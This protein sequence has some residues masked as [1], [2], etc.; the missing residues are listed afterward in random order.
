MLKRALMWVFIAAGTVAAA[1]ANAEPALKD[2]QRDEVVSAFRVETLYEDYAGKVMGGRFRHLPTG[3]VLDVLRIQSVPQGFIWVNSFPPSD[4]GE[5]HTCEHLLLGKGTKGRYVGSLEAMSLGESSAFTMQLQTCYHFHTS[6]GPDTFYDLLEAK[7][8]ALLHPNFS[9]EE[10]RREVCNMGY[11]IDPTDSSIRLEEKGTV[12]N[13]MVSGF[14]RPGSNVWRQLG[15]TLYGQGHPLARSSGGYPPAIRTMTPEDMRSFHRDNYHLGN[16]GMVLAVPDEIPLADLLARASDIFARVQPEAELGSDPATA[17]DR[18]PP[19]VSAPGGTIQLVG[20]PH[21]NPDEPGLLMYA[22]PPQL[23]LDNNEEYLLELFIANIAGG[24]TSDL[25][26]KFI[27]SR[28]REIDLGANAV[29]GWVSTEEGYPVHIGLNNV[30]RDALEKPMI[31]SVRSIIQGEIARVVAFAD[32]S[33]DLQAFNERIR[34]KVI[35]RRRDLRDFLN[36]PPGFGFRGSGANWYEHLKHLQKVKGF[37]KRI[38]LDPELESVEALLATG[39]NFWKEY[40][41]RW[42]LIDVKPYAI[43]GR[44]DPAM[45]AESEAARDKRIADFVQKLKQQYGAATEAEAIA[46]FKADY[47]RKTEEIEAEASRIPMPKFVDNPP[48]TLDAQLHYKVDT[49]ADGIPDVASTFD[50]MPG[51]TIG[52]ALD[53]HAVPESLLV[54]AAALP[55]LLTEVGVIRDGTPI[56]YDEMKEAIR[57][58]ILYLRAYYDVNP[59]TER[60]ELVLK[61]SGSELNESRRALQWLSAALYSPD[62][63]PENLP[64]IRDAVAL[65][66]KQIR[67]TMRYSEESWVEN[68]VYAYWRQTDPLLL[69]T[70]SFLTRTHSLH[71][72]RWLL[73]DP[74]DSGSAEAFTDFMAD[75]SALGGRADR[76]QLIALLGQITAGEEIATEIPWPAAGYR[77]LTPEARGFV[78][79]AAGALSAALN[80]IPD[81]TLATDWDYLCRQ[82]ATDLAV[83]PSAALN[84][85]KA[86]MASLRHADNARSFMVSSTDSKAALRPELDKVL[87]GLDR[88]PVSRQ[89]YSNTPVITAHLRERTPGLDRPVF[90]GLVN[91]NTRSGVFVNM[92]DCTIYRDTDRETLLKFLTSRLYGGHGAHS[93]FMKTWGAGLAYSNGLRHYEE[94]GRMVY[95]AERCPD[96]AQ[97]MQ[98]V[99]NEL[100]RAP[101]DTTLGDYAVA[102]AFA[103]SRAA[104]DYDHRGEAQAADL[105]DGVTPDNVK[106]FRQSILALRDSEN[107]YD[108]LQS[109]M[110]ATYGEVLPGY[111]PKAADVPEAVYFVIGPEKQFRS[112]EEYLQGAGEAGP[113]YRL[114]PRDFWLTPNGR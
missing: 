88:R 73:M 35:E 23:K 107:L 74:G 100:K 71:R 101:Y 93:M 42:R 102:Q 84:K 46:Q 1:A 50:N 92:S 4:Q 63:R 14:E 94:S 83:P 47:D 17:E 27:D 58:E 7:L 9:D 24:E 5:P 19:P 37:R 62:W 3:F 90:V 44:P 82:M 26:R 87:A 40:I 31:D 61:A 79:E 41:G 111:G 108:Q 33:E 39:K 20:F 8:D 52:I 75:L 91:E 36:S 81:A 13:E 80:E 97:T 53:M 55:L 110:E 25:Y 6:A 67:N 105:A 15:L 103:V 114:Y 22:W 69:A 45:L 64:R 12:Y 109:R 77:A 56:A 30:R 29:F 76:A 113:V 72:L 78:V 95:Y 59:L 112:F 38:T 10:M 68:P 21:Q 16:M 43:A 106:R 89:T 86:V 28:T 54:Y 66:L 11:A 2:L 104:G 70:G 85:L 96:L 60:S 48:L 34:N 51:A 57:R 49:L 32:G 99:V 65:G 98:F 18:L